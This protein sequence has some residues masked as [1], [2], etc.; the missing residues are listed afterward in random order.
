MA[1]GLG[2]T[3]AVTERGGI[4]TSED[5]TFWEPRDSHTT[6]ALRAVTFFGP[7]LVITGERGTLLY[8]DSLQEFHVESFGTEDWLEGV[9]SSTNLLVAVGDN[10]A[11][12]T[13]RKSVV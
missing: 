13:D 1:Y 8:A 11:I 3:V 9:T 4:F 12:Y 5:L 7:R 2:L 6:N 10:G